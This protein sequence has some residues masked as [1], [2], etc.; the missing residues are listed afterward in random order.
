VHFC[1]LGDIAGVVV[2]PDGP[3][4]HLIS[5]SGIAGHTMRRLQE[6]T[7]SWPPGSVIVLHSDGIGSH[8]SLA[9]YAGL[10]E[11]RPD[12]IAGV[13]Y[14]DFRQDRADAT[15]VVARHAAEPQP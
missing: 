8:W 4:Q 6:F 12:V 1:G 7:Y 11:R 3:D 5:H 15:V 9:K 10:S 14:R 13:L 2:R